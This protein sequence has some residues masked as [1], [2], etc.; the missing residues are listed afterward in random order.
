[1]YGAVDLL[2]VGQFGSATDVSA[3]STGSQ[4]MHSITTVIT[5]LAMGITIL[6][7]QK[8][9]MKQP[10]EAGRTIGSGICFFAVLSL[11]L[12][13]LML[14]FA[15]GVTSIMLVPSAFMQSMSAFVAQN[16]GAR[17]MGRA[18]KSLFYGIAASF[19]VGVVMFWLA[20]FHG[21]LYGKYRFRPATF[22]R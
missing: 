1:M 13:A 8:I 9:G 3:V 5:G 12:T 11:G 14:L 2:V 19:C 15:E 4:I 7:G 22:H 10:E 6:A 17:K 18:D 21:D 16:V 20:F